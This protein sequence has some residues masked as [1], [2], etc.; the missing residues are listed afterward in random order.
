MNNNPNETQTPYGGYTGNATVHPQEAP[1]EH[2]VEYYQPPEGS[3]Q[4]E[5]PYRFQQPEY[6]YQQQQTF[7]DQK[8]YEAPPEREISREQRTSLG[9]KACTAGWLSYFGGWITGLIFLLLEKENRFV[10]F[11][12]MQSLIFFGAMNILTTVFNAIP[13]LRFVGGGLG[14]VS[15]VCWIVL[16]VAAGRGRYYKLPLIG[17]YAEQWTNTDKR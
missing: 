17:D 6:E 2:P 16:M 13:F 8:L 5:Q 1:G 7:Q 9:M 11:H 15:F 3:Q 4:P 14:I 10:R 12:A